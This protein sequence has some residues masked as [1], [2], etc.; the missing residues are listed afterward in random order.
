MK[1][2]PYDVIISPSREMLVMIPYEE[3]LDEPGSELVAHGADYVIRRGLHKHILEGL[4]EKVL[5][6]GGLN[7]DEVLV[8]EIDSDETVRR[9]TTTKAVYLE[10]HL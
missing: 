9:V 6:G 2:I 10:G 5:V 8:S 7:S 3:G 1:A 4:A